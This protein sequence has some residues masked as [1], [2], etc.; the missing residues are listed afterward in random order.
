MFALP[1]AAVLARFSLIHPNPIRRLPVPFNLHSSRLG[2]CLRPVAPLQMKNV[3]LAT[4]ILAGIGISGA[5]ASAAGPSLMEN[6]GRGVVAMRTSETAVFVGWRVLGTDPADIAFNLYRSTGGGAPVKL[7]ATPITAGTNWTDTTADL[8]RSNA[9][10]VQPIVFGIEGAMSGAWT[11][12]AASPVQQHLRVPLMRPAGGNVPDGDFTYSP[13][14]ISPADLDGDGTYEIV[15][16]WEPSN[17]RDPSQDGYSG[18]TIFDAYKLDGARLWRIELGVNIRSGA[19]DTPLIVYDF[20][21]DGRAE[22][23]LKTAPGTKDGLGNFVADPAKFSGQ[24]PTEAFAHTADYRNAS[25]RALAGPEFLTVFDGLTGAELTSTRY[26]PWRHPTTDFETSAQHFEI[27]GDTFGNRQA[28]IY[29]P[30]VAYLDGQRPSIVTGRG[31]AGGQSGHPGRIALGA[32]NWR[33]GRLTQL[34]TF[35]SLGHPMQAQ[36]SG[37]GSHT[38][39]VAD[40]NGDGRDDIVYGQVFIDADGR[41]IST[42]SGHGDAIH[43]SSMDPDRTGVQ[44]FMPHESP[45]SYGPNALSFRDGS[46]ALIW[47]VSA[48]GDIGRGVAADIDPRFPG[49]EM[50]G[51]GGTGGLYNAQLRVPNAVLGPRAEQVSTTKPS[52]INHAVWWDGDLLRELLDGT[53]VRKWNWN[54][55]AEETFFAPTGLASNNGSKSNPGLQADLFGDW[56]EEIIWREA[57]NEAVR[58]YTTTIPTAHR[59]FTL[60]HD[61]QYRSGVASQ[62]IGYN[63]PPHPRFHLGQHMKVAPVANIVTALSVLLGPPAPVFTGVT[64]DTGASASDAV[65]SSGNLALNG[66][67]QANTTVVVTRLGVGAIGTVPS[68][69]GGTWSLGYSA[70]TLPEGVHLFTATANDGV[71]TGAATS[72]PFRVRVD[73]TPPPAP[74]ITGIAHDAGAGEFIF[75]GSAEPGSIVTVWLGG[76]GSFGS[77]VAEAD[78]LW[79]LIYDGAPPAPGSLSFTARAADLAGNASAVSS[80]FVVDTTIVT[81]VITAIADDTGISNTDGVTSD[82]TLVISGTGGAGSTVTVSVVGQAALGTTTVDGSGNWAFSPSAFAAGTIRL[83]AS[84]SSGSGTSAS[85]PGFAVTID[86][87]APT[88]LS[89]NRINPLA[90][91]TSVGVLTFKVTFSEPVYG[92]AA[93]DFG[94]T[95]SIGQTGAITNV[96][97]ASGTTVDVTVVVGAEG[98]VRLDVKGTATIGDAAG[99]N[100]AS[101]F[102]TGQMFNRIL[103]GDGTWIRGT[104]GGLWSAFANWDNGIIGSGVNNTAFFDKI[105]LFESTEVRLDSPRSVG[106]LIFG[107]LDIST[108]GSWIV[109]DAGNPAN[110]LTM[111][112]TAGAPSINVQPLGLNSTATLNVGLASTVG[113]SKQGPGTLVLTRPNT[114]S[115]STTVAAGTLRLQDASTYN[116]STVSISSGGA[117]L[118]IAGG[119]FA[120]TGTL[121]VNAGGGSALVVDGGVANFAAL[122]TSN[123]PGGI[124]RINGGTVT[125]ASV[126]LPRSNDANQNFGVGFIVAGG[127]V[128]VNGTIGLGT[129]NSN[130]VM[131]VDGGTL[132]ANGVVQLG[133]Q[134]SGGRGGA[135]R[136]TGNAR[137]ES[138]HAATGVNIVARQNNN[139][140]AFFTGGVS[141]VERFTLGATGVTTGLATLNING[142]TVYVG[143][144]GIVRIAT[145]PAALTFGS[146]VLGAKANWSTLLP[147]TL[148]S[149]GNIAIKAGAENDA[150]FDITL[151]GAL[152]GAGGLTKFGTGTLI[153]SAANTYTGST[154]VAAGTLRVDGTVAAG[155]QFAIDGGVLSG[156][157]T[158][159][160]TVELNSGGAIRAGSPGG[161]ATLNASAAKW[162]G[163]G[164][165]LFNPAVANRLV[166]T[167]ALT[168]GGAGAFE[169]AFD[170]PVIPS[171]WVTLATFG[172]TDFTADDFS[173]S[174]LTGQLGAFVVDSTSLRF[175][176]VADGPSAVFDMWAI[177]EGL[178]PGQ[179]DPEDNPSGDGIKNLMKFVLGIDPQATEA[180]GIV[181][182]TVDAGGGEYPAIAFTRRQDLGGVIVD[183]LVSDSLDFDNLFDWVEVSATD[184]GDGTDLVVVRSTVPLS[185]EPNQFFRVAA[186]IP[187]E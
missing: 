147:I 110:V 142:G 92:I 26:F 78:G 165:L 46:G 162:S 132:V 163:G 77:T 5:P 157:G 167:G 47:G 115:G 89:S 64:P 43:V 144:G 81:P 126:N 24:F 29:H 161:A 36:L 25:G 113:L 128:T 116:A 44:V 171:E 182:S 123:S 107:D 17:A 187:A 18:Q 38:A 148:P 90:Q 183:V 35:D 103:T 138:T 12:A 20:D 31:Y 34:W 176:A 65:T 96:S 186:T 141:V 180:E 100:L 48:S 185:E 27:W 121:T 137:F 87:A 67:A 101:G 61:R 108:S 30:G 71:N 39:V 55:G 45:G 99:N 109:S 73:Q 8:T 68:G 145:V 179:R 13:N 140:T 111:A 175:V 58:I 160:R 150:P 91:N 134:S 76:T 173:Y 181:A 75:T 155:A 88:V 9:Y 79:A 93:D 86:N 114:M 152:S 53:S 102:N 129:N 118:N 32:W 170:G 94:L 119:T 178:P 42:G 63:Q 6:L 95:F 146:G 70:V 28:R 62:N 85:S 97:A 104:S 177:L 122:A 72:P 15:L 74:S 51:S 52:S 174:G 21:G 83:S 127:H 59:F 149:N 11:L 158:V 131:S 7:N 41:L 120:A 106:N 16:K 40:L 130:G 3:I 184:Q 49:Y 57:G 151:S 135:M 98:T 56:R 69:A 50:W 143:S 166:L 164:R 80:A 14:D 159:N 23:V 117:R 172:S 1:F 54:T 169:V 37:Q 136:V 156:G 153:L 10:S 139:S 33:N 133:N 168:K 84:A 66:T 124:L 154:T 19:H 22:V 2:P 112:V 125:A 82:S 4:L 60:M 105:D